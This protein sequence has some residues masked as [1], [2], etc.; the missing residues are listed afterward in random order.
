MNWFPVLVIG[1]G[2]LNLVAWL[3][4]RANAKMRVEQINQLRQLV[5]RS[6]VEG[7]VSMGAVPPDLE[8]DA[9]WRVSLACRIL[10]AGTL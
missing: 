2:A 10:E 1:V 3:I 6:F 5:Y 8:M 7:R 4:E 9:A